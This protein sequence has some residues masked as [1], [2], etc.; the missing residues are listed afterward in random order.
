M[1]CSIPEISTK[2]QHNTPKHKLSDNKN[3]Q[4]RCDLSFRGCTRSEHLEKITNAATITWNT[5]CVCCPQNST[6]NM[7]RHGAMQF[8]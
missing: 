8:L 5:M 4:V 2:V 1:K 6:L 3:L 7:V